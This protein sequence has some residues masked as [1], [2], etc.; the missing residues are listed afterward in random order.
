MRVAQRS[1]R[2]ELRKDQGRTGPREDRLQNRGTDPRTN[3]DGVHPDV[4]QLGPIHPSE[5]RSMLP[6]L[7]DELQQL[8]AMVLTAGQQLLAG[9]G[10]IGSVDYKSATELVTDLDR[11][12]EDQLLEK[13]LHTFPDDAVRGEEGSSSPGRSLRTWYLDPLDGTTNYVH[14]YPFYAVSL[15][16]AQRE[17]LLLGAVFAPYLDELYLTA[18]GWGTV[19]E[20]PVHQVRQRLSRREPVVL[21]RALLAT[22]FPYVRDEIV[23]RN[24][25]YLK[26][27][28]LNQCHGVRRAGSAAIDL[29]HVAA[30]K[31]DGYW[32]M[33]LRPWDVVA[34]C[35]AARE[36]GAVVSD[37]SGRE[38]FLDGQQIVAAAPGL[39][40]QLLEVLRNEPGVG[41]GR[42]ESDHE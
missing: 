8:R 3:R 16:C 11:Q 23:H 4:V 32:E 6:T 19:L 42:T 37:F 41:E 7:P 25:E 29:C 2:S 20:R 24:V 27:F 1:D 39:H 13:L 22:G 9:Q 10:R 14:G 34:G 38:G 31:L 40:A 36:V 12:L 28:L 15:G 33:N 30:G 5:V 35:L 18:R 26:R 17:D 21:R